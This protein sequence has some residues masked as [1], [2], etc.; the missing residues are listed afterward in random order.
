M[1]G[2]TFSQFSV[3]FELGK[4][5]GLLLENISVLIFPHVDGASDDGF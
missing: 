3:P 1:P 2:K 5:M 4:F